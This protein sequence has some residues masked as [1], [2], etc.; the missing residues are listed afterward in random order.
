MTPE[1]LVRW[2]TDLLSRLDALAHQARTTRQMLEA[3]D[4]PRLEVKDEFQDAWGRIRELFPEDF[5]PARQGDLNR[6]IGFAEPHDF[7]DIENHDIP[8]VKMSVESYRRGG[9]ENAI[10]QQE[11]YNHGFEPFELVHPLLRDVSLQHFTQREYGLAA[12]TA[13]ESVM[14]EVRRLSGQG[15]DGTVLVN[16]AI[17]ID[18]GRVAFSQCDTDNERSVTNGLKEIL[19]GVYKGVRNPLAHGWNGYG[20][21]EAYQIIVLCSL[22][23]GRLQFMEI[24]E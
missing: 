2:R 22:L 21:I 6:H 3:R 14:D 10:H 20:R 12:R 4:L 23:L 1:Q 19:Q 15:G 18:A 13:V 8:A 7:F 16:R 17:G 5:Q 11:A 9:L 24:A